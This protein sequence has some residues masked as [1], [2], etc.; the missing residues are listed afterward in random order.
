M[1]IPTYT[2]AEA[3][4]VVIALKALDPGTYTIGV[5]EPVENPLYKRNHTHGIESRSHIGANTKVV[6]KENGNIKG[7]LAG[8]S[9][10]Y[11]VACRK[12]MGVR[13]GLTFAQLLIEHG[14][15]RTRFADNLPEY[16][17]HDLTLAYLVHSGV[18]TK[19][20]CLDADAAVDAMDEAVFYLFKEATGV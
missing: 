6:V 1:K 16:F 10:H 20:Q 5:I 8:C 4:A 7:I 17:R 2:E 13:R 11:V 18:I 15:R 12:E 19:Q 3:T 14:V 9:V